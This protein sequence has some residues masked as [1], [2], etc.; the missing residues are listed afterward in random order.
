[1]VR[2]SLVKI[3][4]DV[5]IEAAALVGC[6]VLTGVGAVLNTARVKAGESVAVI[7]LGGVGLSAL[8][9][10]RLAGAFPI[11]AVD[12]NEDKLRLAADLGATFTVRADLPDVV[13]AIRDATDGGVH[14]AFE[15]AGVT[16]ALDVAYRVTRRG[17][18]TVVAGLPAGNIA[19]PISHASLVAEERTL[20]GSYFGSCV[21][22]R[23][24]PRL[25]RAYQSGRLPIDRIAG[26]TVALDGMNEAFDTLAA[27][28][29]VR[30]VLVPA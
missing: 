23:D 15:T 12:V 2:D 20:K 8:L 9:G 19:M 27:G 7:G 26:A 16:Q 5:P 14:Y 13:A 30:Q 22:V 1:M 18:T 28:I 4:A 6:A 10:A 25:I 11:V 3:D 24:V 29:T 17:G 21:P